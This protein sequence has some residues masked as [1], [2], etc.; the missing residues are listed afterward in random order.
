MLLIEMSFSIENIRSYWK[1][2]NILQSEYGLLLERCLS[3][4]YACERS[5]D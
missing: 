2:S 5:R 4:T 1:I 3:S